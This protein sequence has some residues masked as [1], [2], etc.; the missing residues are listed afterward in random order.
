MTWSSRFNFWRRP[1][2]YNSFGVTPEVSDSDFTYLTGDDFTSPPGSFKPPRLRRQGSSID[3]SD[4]S[5]PDILILKHLGVTYPLHFDPYAIDDGLTIGQVRQRAAEQTGASNPKRIK[6]LYK[7]R[8][9]RE[10]S[11][12]CKDEGLKQQSQIMCVV[13]EVLPDESTSDLSSAEDNRTN[14]SSL[15]SH[16]DDDPHRPRRK[17][18]G[19]KNRRR[20]HP[21]LPAFEDS[22]SS[23]D[24]RLTSQSDPDVFAPPADH[25]PLTLHDQNALNPPMEHRPSSSGRSP[26]PSLG[27]DLRRYLTPYEKVEAL[28]RYFRSSLL[29]M[30]TAYISNPPEDA[31]ARA[32]EHSKLSET[33]LSQVIMK[34]DMIEGGDARNARRA[35]IKEA[36]ET[37]TRLD[38]AKGN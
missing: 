16:P 6:M 33:I 35:L 36:Q 29:P 28:A 8:P 34:A 4:E 26:A 30:C 7:G 21:N 9:L 22:A 17:M 27:P 11:R 38:R 20:N 31:R 25:P 19:R 15:S 37:L 14:V 5:A 13:S 3:P 2:P 12:P 18:K 32:F 24:L 10:D 23:T 1:S